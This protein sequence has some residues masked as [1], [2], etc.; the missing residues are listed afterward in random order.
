MSLVDDLKTVVDLA[1]KQE[2]NVG[3]YID[4]IH[5][6]MATIQK[7]LLQLRFNPKGID[8]LYGQNTREAI[9]AFQ[10]AYGIEQ[11][12]DWPP[13]IL[14]TPATLSLLFQKLK[15]GETPPTQSSLSQELFDYYSVRSNYDSVDADVMGWFG[16][17]TNGCAAFCSTALRHIGVNVPHTNGTNGYNI[18]TVAQSLADWLEQQGWERI[19]DVNLILPGNI[20]VTQD[21]IEYP[22]FAAHIWVTATKVNEGFSMAIDNQGFMYNRNV[23]AQGPKTPWKYAL[24]K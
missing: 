22:G 10:K 12:G 14:L 1:S 21:D 16:T 17:H 23:S 2:A 18:S 15:A 20:V 8:G 3:I 6:N 5:N 7:S 4:L 19:T 11:D 13:I 9:L 24:R